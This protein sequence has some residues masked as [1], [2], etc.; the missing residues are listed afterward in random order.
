M[1]LENKENIEARE[2]II[3]ASI[4]LF[5]KKGF[6]AASVNEIAEQANVTKALIY[7]Y[8]KSKEEIL[9]SLVHSLMDNIT[10]IAMDF[11]HA[12][13]VQTIK[14]GKLDIEPDRLRFVDE[15]ARKRFSQNMTVYFED[16][17]NYSIE[18]RAVI[19]ILMLESL[20]SSKHHNDL[21]KIVDL[22]SSDNIIFKTISEADKDFNYSDDMI[23]FKFF[24][25]TVP[26]FNFAAYY[27][28]YK[29]ISGLSDEKLLSS[30]LQSVSIIFS[31]LISGSNILLRNKYSNA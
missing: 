30:F 6:D 7:Y 10:S 3:N 8:F 9:D 1:F 28:D 12:N 31:S 14:D 5:S 4:E 15:E 17:L 20:K 19:R 22:T 18:H 2:R 29:D 27:D 11:I 16:I 21:F 26:L 13:I 23:L 24:F 25:T